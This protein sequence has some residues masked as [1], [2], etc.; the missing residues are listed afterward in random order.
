M[1]SKIENFRNSSKKFIQDAIDT[2]KSVAKKVTREDAAISTAISGGA[3]ATA[4]GV[5][6][7]GTSTTAAISAAGATIGSVTGGVIGALTGSG[8]GLATGGAGMAATVPFAAAG[9][10]LGTTIGG[11]A[12]TAAALVGIGTAPVWAVPIAVAGGVAMTGGA[13]VAAYKFYKHKQQKVGTESSKN[14]DTSVIES[15]GFTTLTKKQMKQIDEL[16]KAH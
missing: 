14:S 11:Y 1:T 2:T 10:A 12:G 9:S 16:E 15:N 4:A 13:T 8:I 3:V 7:A 6:A 5:V